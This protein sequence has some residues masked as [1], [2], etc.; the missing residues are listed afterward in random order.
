MNTEVHNGGDF[1]R[2]V[3]PA[4]DEIFAAFIDNFQAG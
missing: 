2:G 1:I 4:A 3:V